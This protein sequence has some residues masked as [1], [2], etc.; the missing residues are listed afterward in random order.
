MCMDEI[1][2]SDVTRFRGEMLEYLHASHADLVKSVEGEK[3]FTDETK[4]GL[5]S[6]IEAFK[7]QFQ[8]T[9]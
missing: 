9:V 5:N 1:P 7:T 3:K 6:A 2:V 4:A 8:P